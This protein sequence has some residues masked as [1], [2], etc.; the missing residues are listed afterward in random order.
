MSNINIAIIG[1][2]PGGLTLA[3]LLQLRGIK[4]RVF[5]Q[6]ASATVRS[7]GGCLDLH[8]ES[9]QLAL[10]T[11]GLE[12][13]FKE[14][15][16]YDGEDFKLIDKHGVMHITEV[17]EESTGER[18]EIDRKDLRQMLLDSVEPNSI[19]WGRSVKA[20]EEHS[21]GKY[22]IKVHHNGEITTEGPFDLVVG[23]DGAWSRIRT[24]VS[25]VKP[26][27]SGLT[28]IECYFDKDVATKHPQISELCAR[29]SMFAFTK[30]QGLMTQRQGDGSIRLYIALLVPENWIKECGIP[31]E[32]TVVAKQMLM[33]VYAGWDEKM[34][35]LIRLSDS[36]LIPRTM[37][38]LPIGTTWTSK[39]GVTLIGDSA[40]L[41][42]PFAGEG[43]NL[44]MKDALDLANAI[45]EET[46]LDKAVSKFEV[47]MHVRA[48]EAAE[49]TAANL[50]L[51]FA[52]NAPIEFLQ[53]M[54][55]RGPPPQE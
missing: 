28:M 30:G 36:V 27:Y 46:N 47:N 17:A 10:K 41:M 18:P 29:G 49:Q 11:A 24:L 13:K 1:A 14:K 23:A 43:V 35:D 54:K 20:V 21:A 37:Y 19:L 25:D 34:L 55:S 48:K 32:N 4:P 40:H 38:Q 52:E 51:C 31:F 39:S 7:Q 33:D 9:G 22:T 6:E 44:A 3:K 2:G 5:E 8:P 12:D 53:I 26:E 16:R 15:A 42:T 50:A 45:T